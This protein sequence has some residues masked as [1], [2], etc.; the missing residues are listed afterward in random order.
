M[1]WTL[2][3]IGKFDLC[4]DEDDLDL[5]DGLRKFLAPFRDLTRLVSECSPNLSLLCH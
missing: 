2:K 4:L 5:L 3:K 1:N